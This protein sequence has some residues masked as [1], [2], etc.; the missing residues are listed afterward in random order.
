MLDADDAVRDMLDDNEA[1]PAPTTPPLLSAVA[2]P[3]PYELTPANARPP[4]RTGIGLP[5][6]ATVSSAGPEKP[7]S[8]PSTSDSSLDEGSNMVGR[9]WTAKNDDRCRRR[10]TS[11]AEIDHLDHTHTHTH[12]AK[13]VRCKRRFASDDEYRTGVGCGGGGIRSAGGGLHGSATPAF[14]H[15]HTDNLRQRRSD[16]VR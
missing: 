8:S 2:S 12:T 1:D 4:P 13:A 3:N 14:A 10:A 16:D 6:R 7:P 9:N 11:L 5:G 15:F